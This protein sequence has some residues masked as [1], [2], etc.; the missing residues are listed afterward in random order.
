MPRQIT[1]SVNDVPIKLEVYVA[2]V[3][4]H[5]VSALVLSLHDTGN[6]RDLTLTVDRGRVAIMLNGAPVSLKPFPMQIITDTLDGMVRHLKGV[7]GQV[8]TLTATIHQ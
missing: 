7:Q 5:V 1:L 4:Y 6:I 8:E 3:V 2:E